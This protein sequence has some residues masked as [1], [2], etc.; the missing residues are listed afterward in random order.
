[1]LGAVV[2]LLFCK[3]L[4][5]KA[6]NIRKVVAWCPWGLFS[7]ESLPGFSVIPHVEACGGV[8]HASVWC[9]GPDIACETLSN[10]PSSSFQLTPAL[11]RC[12]FSLYDAGNICYYQT[13]RFWPSEPW[14]WGTWYVGQNILPLTGQPQNLLSWSGN[15][16]LRMCVCCSLRGTLCMCELLT[17][18]RD[19]FLLGELEECHA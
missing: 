17:Q 14:F 10:H 7:P 18:P 19:L 4:L 11:G 1:M 6:L 5:F 8:A 3:Y 2:Q 16:G 12:Q 15:G 9:T 13:L